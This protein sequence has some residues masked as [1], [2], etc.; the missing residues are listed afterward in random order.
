V[1]VGK[2]SLIYIAF[3]ILQKAISFVL[4]PVL[5]YFIT[6]DGM[7]KITLLTTLVP[8][9][10]M[11]SSLVLYSAGT[12]FTYKFDD[13]VRIKQLWG[14]IN[15]A[16]NCFGVVFLLIML[17][18][19]NALRGDLFEGLLYK[20]YI[21]LLL[22]VFFNSVYNQYQ[23]YLQAVKKVKEFTKN[24]MIFTLINVFLII[25]AVSVLKLG[26]RGYYYAYAITSAIF[27]FYAMWYA[28]KNF[29]FT[30]DFKLIKDCL[31]YSLPLIPHAT[32]GF[33]L[34]YTDRIFV[35]KYLGT[36]E[37]GVYGVACQF[38][39]IFG[40]ITS[41]FISAYSPFSFEKMKQNDF[42]P[43]TKFCYKAL[44]IFGVVVL[45]VS[46]FA[47]DLLLLVVQHDFSAGWVVLPIFAVAYMFQMGYIFFVTVLFYQKPY[48][49]NVV[50]FC[51]GALNV[52]LN[53]YLTRKF[54]IIGA[55]TCTLVSYLASMLV[56]Y[57]ISKRILDIGFSLYR[58]L[59]F[60]I[61]IV[62]AILISYFIAYIA[63]GAF[64]ALLASMF[65][66][67]S[68]TLSLLLANKLF[69]LSCKQLIIQTYK[70]YL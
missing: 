21:V 58:I 36:S 41:G 24:A 6:K 44:V 56:V 47:R 51:S 29:I 7:G 17:A 9:F 23:A 2:N 42:V 60:Q 27:Y 48:L 10:A 8:M 57:F 65:S 64:H 37:L 50:T 54:G 19:F 68:I 11:Y 53:I 22:L 5:T 67:L 52:I 39:V 66:L 33:F 49:V 63:S 1:S 15:L 16:T 26:Y 40:M 59:I 45:S 13:D 61:Y 46:F 70:R 18:L 12:V 34:A 28:F 4:L 43:I 32:F 62:I 35:N 69:K 20:D 31:K 3:S 55:T 14:N 25:I 30:I 38:A